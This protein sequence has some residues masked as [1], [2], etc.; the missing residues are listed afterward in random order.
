VSATP[1][2]RPAT[3]TGTALVFEVVPFPSCL[4]KLEPQQLTVP[5]DINSA[6]V[7]AFPAAI[8]TAPPKLAMLTG[9][10]LLT[11]SPVPSCPL[12]LSPQQEIVAS[13]RIAQV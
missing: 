10:I 7:W 8:E 9:E 5:W 12:L 3:A 1:F 13:S 6:Q 11:K 2:I 4:L